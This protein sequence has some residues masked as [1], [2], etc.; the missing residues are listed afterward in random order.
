MPV[1]ALG[2]ELGELAV[3]TGGRVGYL[4][5]TLSSTSSAGCPSRPSG[6]IVDLEFRL[7]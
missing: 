1:G 7:A 4:A 3:P 6:V 5:S 2:A